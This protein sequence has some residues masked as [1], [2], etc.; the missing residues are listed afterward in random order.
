[1]KTTVGL[2]LLTC[3][4]LFAAHIVIA[5]PSY[6]SPTDVDL[7]IGCTC[8]VGFSGCQSKVFDAVM[9]SQRLTWT[10]TVHVLASKPA[11]LDAACFRKRDVQGMGDGNC[12]TV[13]GDD[14]KSI[15]NLFRGEPQ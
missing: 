3:W 4:T 11:N 5:N 8:V 10:Q 13:P 2:C 12:C 15:A 9:G 7:Q 1:M 14:D 6:V